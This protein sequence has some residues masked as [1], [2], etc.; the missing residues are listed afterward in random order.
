MRKYFDKLK[1]CS[2]SEFYAQVEDNIINKKRMFIIT[3]NPET[4]EIANKNEDFNEM[5]LD[6]A[7]T[8]VPDGIGIVKASRMLGYPVKE[9]ITG[10]D[11]AVKLFE[12]ANNYKLNVALLGAKE[13]IIQTLV[14][15][16]HEDYPSLNIV[17]AANGYDYDKD[18]FFESIKDLDIDVC[19]VALGIPAQERL[20]YKHLKKFNKG[21]F[22]GVGGSFDVLSG[23]KKR[24][25]KIFQKLN[26]EWLYRI[27]TEPKR[28]KRFYN[29]N[30][31]FMFKVRKLKKKS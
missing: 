22:V 21:I 6:E 17:A 23:L 27:T 9:R 24:A 1:A 31:K 15:K 19:L 2:A 13:E 26:L 18:Q 8:I 28:L 10:V 20:I 12:Y 7:T 16:L 11:L 4:F 29:S 14:K 5:V 30:V 3:A 25:P